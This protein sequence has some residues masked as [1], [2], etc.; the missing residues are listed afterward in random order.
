VE[1]AT[2]LVGEVI[3]FVIS[4]QVDNRPIGQG[5]RLIENEP[6]LLDTR[7]EG[8]HAITVRLSRLPDKPSRGA[9]KSIDV[10]KPNALPPSP[11]RHAAVTTQP[12]ATPSIAS[13]HGHQRAERRA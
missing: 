13:V 3:A 5:S 2:L 12:K 8:T 7:A 9:A 1:R 11:S 10:F 4:D 6:P